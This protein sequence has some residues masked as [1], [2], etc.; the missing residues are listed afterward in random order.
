MHSSLPIETSLWDFSLFY[1]GRPGVSSLCLHLQDE[2]GVNVNILLW[3][4]WLG[5]R[6]IQ[7]E[8]TQLT[9]ALRKTHSWD[10][11]YVLPLRQLR[12][13]MKAEFGVAD[14][15]IET[16]R[17]QIKHAELLAEKHLQQLLE[18]H[19][20]VEKIAITATPDKASMP[21]TLMAD[22]LQLYLQQLGIDE[23]LITDLLALL[24]D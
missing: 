19:I 4:L 5:Y 23:S 20:P 13:Q 6:G 16:V 12:R 21:A 24:L 17:A 14:R 15:S 18:L 2:H 7:L 22:N 8:P 10:Q 1:Y 11:Q 3:T 9:L